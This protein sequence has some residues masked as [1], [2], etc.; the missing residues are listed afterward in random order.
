MDGTLTR[1]TTPHYNRPGTKG[2]EGVLHILQTN[3]TGALPSNGLLSY[4]G[5]SSE[6]SYSSSEM[7]SVSSTAPTDWLRFS[8]FFENLNNTLYR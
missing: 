7:Q 4:P 2:D 8:K 5:P 3:K 6:R 1:T